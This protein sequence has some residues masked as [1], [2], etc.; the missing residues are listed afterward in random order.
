MNNKKKALVLVSVIC[1]SS[2]LAIPASAMSVETNDDISISNVSPSL[3][4]DSYKE[5]IASQNN[6]KDSNSYEAQVFLNEFNNLTETEQELFVSYINDSDLLLD[7]M[8]SLFNNE[9]YVELANGD[10][11]ISNSQT[12]SN[13][14]KLVTSRAALQY[15]KG[16]ASANV[17]VLGVKVF[18]YSGEIRYGHNGSAIKEISHA[19]IWIS[20]NWLPLLDFSWD[21]Q[22]TYG[23][24]TTVAHHIKYCTWS[25]VHEKFGVTYGTHQIEITGSVSNSTTFTVS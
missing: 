15:R 10:I 24:G 5:W 18:E 9:D 23:I 3:N 1:L 4:V 20:T 17:S 25:F 6:M 2:S 11:V 13:E 22:T 7:V 21:N 14:E 16:T 12:L 8:N 19:N